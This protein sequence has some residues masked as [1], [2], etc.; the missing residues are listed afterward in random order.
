[1]LDYSLFIDPGK[2]GCGFALFCEGEL[3]DAGWAQP[4]NPDEPGG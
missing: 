2:S 1:M 4:T 3:V